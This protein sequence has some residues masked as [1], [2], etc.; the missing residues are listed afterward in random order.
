M[1]SNLV[2]LVIEDN[3]GD[4]HLLE[5]SFAEQAVPARLFLVENGVQA[6][7]FLSR[8]GPYAG[9]PTPDLILLDLNLPIIQGHKILDILRST[10]A[11]ATIPVLV[12]SSSTLKKDRDECARHAIEAYLVKPSH[13]DG[14][15]ELARELGACCRRIIAMRERRRTATLGKA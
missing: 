4:F 3:L 5:E 10:A 8:Q 15:L 6:L 1:D 7:A 9:M 13:F 12:L 11:W 2:A 14:Y